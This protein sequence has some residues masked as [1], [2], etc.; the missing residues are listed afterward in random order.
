MNTVEPE[1]VIAVFIPIITVIVAGAVLIFYIYTKHKLRQSIVEKGLVNENLK[2][3]FEE[4]SENQ[5]KKKGGA[6]KSGII[7]MCFGIGLFV[8]FYIESLG[9]DNGKFIAPVVFF[10]T[11]IGFILITLFD[12]YLRKQENKDEK[13]PE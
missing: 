9:G 2:Y 10:F 7:L 6:A 5:K 1:S 12:K 3:L 13:N 4:T 8:V 11:G